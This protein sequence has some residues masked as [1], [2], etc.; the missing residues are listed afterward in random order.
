[1]ALQA[2][3]AV[4]MRRTRLGDSLGIREGAV[5]GPVVGLRDGAVEGSRVGA[6]GW[7]GEGMGNGQCR[8]VNGR[9]AHSRACQRAGD[10]SS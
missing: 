5:V 10:A 7:E 6:C 9:N 4:V 3:R 1:V 8:R 2:L